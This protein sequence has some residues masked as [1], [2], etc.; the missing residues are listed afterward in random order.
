MAADPKQLK[1]V[2]NLNSRGIAFAIDR[3]PKTNRV[4]YGSS[5]FKVYELDVGAKKPDS[6][7]LEGAGH[8]SYVTCVVLAGKSIVTGSYDCQLVWWDAGTKKQVRAVKDAHAKRIRRLAASPDGLIVASVSDDM[9]VKLWDVATGKLKATLKDHKPMT[10]HHYPSMLYAVAF[11]HDG[12]LLA[13]ADKVGHIVVW[14]VATAKKVKSLEAPVMYTWDPRQRRHS[15]G[16]IRS[17]AFS[18]D[19]RLLAVGGIGK[20]GNID[21]LGGPS[22]IEIFDWKA[23]KR[24]HQIEDGKFKGL[25]EQ[26]SF[27]PDGNW[28]VVAGGDHNGFISIYETK[29]GKLIKQEKAPMHVHQFVVNEDHDTIFAVGHQKVVTWEMKVPEP[30]KKPAEKKPA[31]KKPAKKKKG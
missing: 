15:I 18:G 25:V 29:S 9:D 20:I 11:S 28:F 30:K 4:F 13:T 6:K 12:K 23:G 22:R 21:H 19:D 3:V 5:D 26:I 2:K 27:H 17:V 16:G 1:I 24:L 8:Q 7:A 31:E 10:P 14:D